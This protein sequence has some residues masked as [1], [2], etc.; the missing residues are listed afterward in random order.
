MTL[1]EYNKLKHS[2]G[3]ASGD[4][5]ELE[6]FLSRKCDPPGSCAKQRNCWNHSFETVDR[7]SGD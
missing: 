7:E 6:E 5:T 4:E 3:Q 2:A 1:D